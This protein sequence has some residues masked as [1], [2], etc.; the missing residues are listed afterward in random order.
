MQL[1]FVNDANVNFKSNTENILGEIYI[2]PDFIANCFMNSKYVNTQLV[3]IQN[4]TLFQCKLEKRT[5]A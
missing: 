4:T 2:K 1:K 5:C 3:L